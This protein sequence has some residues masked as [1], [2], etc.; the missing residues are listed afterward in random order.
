MFR[1]LEGVRCEYVPRNVAR[2]V[3]TGLRS[4]G[5]QTLFIERSILHQDAWSQV[6]R[7]ITGGLNWNGSRRIPPLRRVRAGEVLPRRD[8]DWGI[9]NVG[10]L[11]V[12]L[13]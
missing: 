4:A 1:L 5:G 3:Q 11:N 6:Q 2:E 10:S 7:E 13:P 9:A 8:V 12:F